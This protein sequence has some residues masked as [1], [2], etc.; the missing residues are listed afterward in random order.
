MVTLSFGHQ[1]AEVYDE[2]MVL[3]ILKSAGGFLMEKL[4]VC[5]YACLLNNG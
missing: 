4:L 3:N 1:K 2:V 5:V